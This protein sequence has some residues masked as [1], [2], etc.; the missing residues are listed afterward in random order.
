MKLITCHIE[1]LTNL[2]KKHHVA[3]LYVFG[4][5]ATM[6]F[7]SASDIDFLVEFSAIDPLEYFDNY[8]SLKE[9]LE[10]L[11]GRHVDLVEVQTLK[12]PIL[13]RSIDRD[14]VLIYE[15][16]DTEMAI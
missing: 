12:N 7:T 11:F 3:T 9:S 8:M 10:Q 6:H 1:K 14:K 4:S 5:V 2:C 16:K 15:R 13:K